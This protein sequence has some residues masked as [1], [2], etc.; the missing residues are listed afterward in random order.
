LVLRI[1]VP[2]IFWGGFPIPITATTD[3][4]LKMLRKGEKDNG[5]W[6]IVKPDYEMNW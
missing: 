4:K 3:W 2:Y 5:I 6:R 1:S